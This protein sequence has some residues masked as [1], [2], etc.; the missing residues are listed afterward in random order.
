VPTFV[1]PNIPVAPISLPPPVFSQSAQP[2]A[3][4]EQRA[5]ANHGDEILKKMKAKMM[6]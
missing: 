6:L 1:P 2:L 3:L 4:P 5:E